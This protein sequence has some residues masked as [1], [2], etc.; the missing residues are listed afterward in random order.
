MFKSL[1]HT[2]L[3]NKNDYFIFERYLLEENFYENYITLFRK[4]F[5]MIKGE[6]CCFLANKISF[7]QNRIK[8]NKINYNKET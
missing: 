1:I 4:Q 6:R 3:F 8:I 7:L 2:S 5:S